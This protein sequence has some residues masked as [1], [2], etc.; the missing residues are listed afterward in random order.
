MN[1]SKLILALLLVLAFASLAPIMAQ[2]SPVTLTLWHAKQDAEGDT[3]LALID[4][5]NEANIDV[6]IE[7]VFNPSN[8]LQDSFR[9]AAGAGEGPDIIIWANDA[10]GDWATQNLI[11]PISEMIDS[12]LE[13]QI[14]ESA[15]G[16]VTYNGEIYG[17][18]FSAKT[19]TLFYNEALVPD[20]PETWADVV[21][22]SEELAADGFTGMAFQNGFFHSAGF[23]YALDGALMDEDGNATFPADSE[24][25][26]AVDAYLQFHADMYQLGQDMDSGIIIDGASPNPAFQQGEIGMVYDGI[27]NLGQFEQDLGDDLGVA[28]MPALDNGEV[29]ALFAQTE[30]FYFNQNLADT[31]RL[32]AALA[33]GAFVTSEAGQTIAAEGGLL[34]VNPAV[35]VESENLQTFAEQFAL[36]TPFPNR[37]EMSCFWGPMQ[38]AI[39]AVSEGGEEVSAARANAYEQVQTCIDELHADA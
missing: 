39:T 36:G 2:D 15:W 1:R 33:W 23:L 32:E 8:T 21:D 30:A 19:L 31:E 17:V 10:T 27:W 11:A 38:D 24:G 16:T 7:P 4:A 13:E 35:E 18:P 22:Y 14:T 5:F 25:A 28:L 12:E 20:A 29:P 3:L 9:T 34:P 37:A 6:Q 26:E